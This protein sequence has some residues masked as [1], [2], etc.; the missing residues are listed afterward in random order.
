MEKHLLQRM[1]DTQAA[2]RRYLA[3]STTPP[4]QTLVPYLS[5]LSPTSPTLL[6]LSERALVFLLPLA[7][8]GR[9]QQGSG[10]AF[11]NGF[12]HHDGSLRSRRPNRAASNYVGETPTAQRDR[13]HISVF[14]MLS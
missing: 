14:A 1:C 8:N 13:G 6:A 3:R 12:D 7:C 5:P 11:D 10:D 4:V 9:Q 2:P